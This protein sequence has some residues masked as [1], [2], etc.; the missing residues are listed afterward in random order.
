HHVDIATWAM[1]KTNTGPIS[2]DPVMVKHP[3]PFQN[4]YPTVDNQFNTAT[5]FLINADYADGMQLI[6]RHDL[7]NGILFEGTEGRIFAN[8]GRLSGKAVE[9]LSSRPLPEGAVE[10]IYKDR[11]LTDHFRNFF[12]AVAARK[13]PVS[14]VFSHHRALTTCHLAGIAIRLGRKITWN[15]QAERIIGDD[16]A[17]KLISRDKRKGFEIEM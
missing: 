15:P 10:K 12:D 7:D 11:P 3:V 5:E 9:E 1:G 8:R 4:G 13:E 16:Q 6:I 14:D 17:Q 2:I